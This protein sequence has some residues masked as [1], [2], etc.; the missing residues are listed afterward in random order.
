MHYKFEDFVKDLS[1]LTKGKA[2]LDEVK[3]LLKKLAKDKEFLKKIPVNIK[4]DNPARYLLHADKDNKFA[5]YSV[6]WDKDQGTL[7]HDHDDTWV[8]R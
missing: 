4:K 7:A 1:N 5:I 6:V 3:I 8:L 2:N